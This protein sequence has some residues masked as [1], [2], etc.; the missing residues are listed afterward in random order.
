GANLTNISLSTLLAQKQISNE[1]A[2]NKILERIYQDSQTVSEAMREI[3]WSINPKI[4]K[5]GEA[6]PR[7]LLYAAELL[8]AKNIELK[9]EIIPQVEQLKFSMQQRHDLYLIF[10]E[11]VNNIAKHSKAKQVMINF[12]LNTQILNMIIADDGKG[13]DASAPLVNNGLKNMNE[14]ANKHQWQL[15]VR[16][17]QNAGTTIM[18]NAPIA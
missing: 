8:E 18:L 13:F 15:T 7:M 10:K 5:L 6:L 17:G 1:A 4:D 3:V 9:A 2:V 11:A 12:N 14:R 16:S